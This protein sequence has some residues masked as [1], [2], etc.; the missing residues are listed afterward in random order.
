MDN[1]IIICRCYLKIYN[2]HEAN[3]P[4]TEINN[5]R[6]G[7]ILK[8]VNPLCKDNLGVKPVLYK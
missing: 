4:I 7:N 8:V 1:K 5:M 2:G 6:F 3:P